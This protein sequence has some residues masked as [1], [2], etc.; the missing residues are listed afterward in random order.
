MDSTTPETAPITSPPSQPAHLPCSPPPG[1]GPNWHR[2]QSRRAARRQQANARI[3]APASPPVT[4]IANLSLGDP[5]NPIPSMDTPSSTV[6]HPPPPHRPRLALSALLPRTPFGPSGAPRRPSDLPPS[7]AVLAYLASIAAVDPSDPT[8]QLAAILHPTMETAKPPS[9]S[10][11]IPTPAADDP[12]PLHLYRLSQPSLPDFLADHAPSLVDTWN[13]IFQTSTR[14]QEV[15][16][17]HLGIYPLLHP[18]RDVE[19]LI[20]PSDASAF[21]RAMSAFLVPPHACTLSAD[22]IP[23]RLQ[24]YFRRTTKSVRLAAFTGLPRPLILQL[25]Q[26]AARSP[27]TG[28]ASSIQ[29]DLTH[30]SLVPFPL[31]P[32]APSALSTTPTDS[33]PMIVPSPPTTP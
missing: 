29:W 28:F 17:A 10:S 22:D 7:P 12:R 4:S 13:A 19:I 9:A 25:L 3:A 1:S 16:L 11:T 24:I 5:P 31:S 14:L 18:S 21:C 8:A 15:Q 20:H 32:A 33:I 26:T 23:R 6:I 2:N 27:R 30:V